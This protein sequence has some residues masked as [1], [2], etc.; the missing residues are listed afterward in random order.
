MNA[1]PEGHLANRARFGLLQL[2]AKEGDTPAAD[3]LAAR[4]GILRDFLVLGQF[5]EN[6]QT[7]W[8]ILPPEQ[9]I[10]LAKKQV[11]YLHRLGTWKTAR[12]RPSGYVDLQ[13]Q[14]YGYPD[15]ACA[16]ALC[17]LRVDTA[18]DARFWIGA[19]DGHALYVNGELISRE[20][21]SRPFLI[22]DAF[23]DATLR[24][25]WNRVL[26]KVHNTRGPWGF[27]L[28]CV[29]R[30][31]SPIPGLVVSSEDHEA[32]CP[33]RAKP[34]ASATR[35]VR[36][37]FKKLRSGTWTAAVG[38]WDTQNG[39]L[40]PKGTG[41]KGRWQRFD[42]DPDAP[43]RGPANLLWLQHP[44]LPRCGSLQ[45]TIEV[46]GNG[47]WGVT[48]DGENADDG[49]SGHTL[50]FE[51]TDEGK[52]SRCTW[53]PLRPRALQEVRRAGR[54]GQGAPVRDPAGRPQVVGDD[55]RAADVRRRRRA[56]PARARI[57]SDD[58]GQESRIRARRAAAPQARACAASIDAGCAEFRSCFWSWPRAPT[59][60]RATGRCARSRAS[61]R[62]TPTCSGRRRR[63][64][65]C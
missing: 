55:R 20:P 7:A 37:E 23:G 51:L 43:A 34:D 24:A 19:D 53:Y 62:R 31:G 29:R 10:D 54:G 60:A 30:D 40:T 11:R 17:Y 12:V 44:D 1:L 61:F 42:I 21:G 45:A 26:V 36:D 8:V 39:V 65:P 27:V 63:G 4:L 52:K 59:W 47:K 41:N 58:L 35:V 3:R 16:F 2:A 48:I 64:G 13:N 38:E 32:H 33:P 15:D 56:P 14:G 50:V 18:T 57:R 9:E 22:D 28:R 49:Q 46:S 25:G 6:R 5:H